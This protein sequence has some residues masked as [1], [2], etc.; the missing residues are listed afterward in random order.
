MEVRLKQR[1]ASSVKE[2]DFVRIGGSLSMLIC[3]LG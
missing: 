1:F 2:A 3:L